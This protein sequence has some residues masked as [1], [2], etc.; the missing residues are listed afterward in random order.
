VTVAPLTVALVVVAFVV[1]AILVFGER[2]LSKRLPELAPR[3]GFSPHPADRPDVLQRLRLGGM[4]LRDE[5]TVHALHR[6]E[7]EGAEYLLVDYSARSSSVHSRQQ[8]RR[9][10]DVL[11]L[12]ERL[13]L[14]RMALFV[15]PRFEGLLGGLAEQI[16]A[17][18]TPP[19]MQRVPV[20]NPKQNVNVMVFSPDGRIADKEQLAAVVLSAA[21]H[22]GAAVDAGGDA[23]IVS[24]ADIPSGDGAV[25]ADMRLRNAVTLATTLYDRL[26]R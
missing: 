14:A 12:S 15:M 25:P 3:L 9:T 21:D 19:A 26:R 8:S 18:V 2:S 1:V 11:V 5:L 20:D 6:R 17:A 13:Q 22:V 16:L 10:V 23:I 4:G 24:W 7:D